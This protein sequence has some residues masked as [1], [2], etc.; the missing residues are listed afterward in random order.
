T[1]DANLALGFAGDLREYYIGAQILRDLG[2]S[3]L[4]LLTNNPDKV[5]Q[6]S[7]WGMEI[8]ERVPIEIDATAFDKFYLETKKKRMGHILENLDEHEPA[9]DCPSC[10]AKRKNL[11]MLKKNL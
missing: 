3:E 2:A 9:C 7:D 6:L 8:V 1:L 10:V 4:R 5:Y 11:E